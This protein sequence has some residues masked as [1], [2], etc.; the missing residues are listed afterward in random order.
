MNF[1]KDDTRSSDKCVFLGD[2]MRLSGGLCA[3]HRAKGDCGYHD[4]DGTLAALDVAI[5][6]NNRLG[7]AVAVGR[8]YQLDLDDAASDL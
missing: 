4:A 7:G 1:V 8:G 3:D 5:G 6:A 2:H